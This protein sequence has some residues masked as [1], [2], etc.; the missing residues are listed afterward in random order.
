[1]LDHFLLALI[2]VRFSSMN[3]ELMWICSMHH[4]MPYAIH[5]TK[6]HPRNECSD[7][8]ERRKKKPKIE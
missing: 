5:E 7:D 4:L 6:R 3:E 8:N 1:M 2:I